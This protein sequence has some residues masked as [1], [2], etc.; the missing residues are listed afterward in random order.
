MSQ[1]LVVTP[2]GVE[3]VT[4]LNQAGADRINA[5]DGWSA[6]YLGRSGFTIVHED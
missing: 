2:N 1:Y 5:M 4:E 6:V 3:R